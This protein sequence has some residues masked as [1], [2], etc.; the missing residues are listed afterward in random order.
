MK[1]VKVTV[2]L[3]KM[4]IG[5]PDYCAVI[6]IIATTTFPLNISFGVDCMFEVKLTF[7]PIAYI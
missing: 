3:G 6:K 7:T 5:S 2:G 4:S 1:S